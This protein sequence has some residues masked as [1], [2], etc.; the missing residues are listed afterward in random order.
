MADDMMMLEMMGLLRPNR[1]GPSARAGKSTGAMTNVA[2]SQSTG[3][4]FSA[5]MAG[6]VT[7]GGKDGGNQE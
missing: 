2:P 7:S 1:R 3:P 5:H 6:E 4:G